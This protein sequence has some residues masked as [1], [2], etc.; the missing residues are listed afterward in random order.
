MYKESLE[1]VFETV[2]EEYENDFYRG[3]YWNC[4]VIERIRNVSKHEINWNEETVQ[5]EIVGI[6]EGKRTVYYTI[7]Y[8][9][10]SKNREA[11]I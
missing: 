11:V 9:R 8:E 10:S 6:T 1:K 4:D 3:Y 7:K 5:E 2:L